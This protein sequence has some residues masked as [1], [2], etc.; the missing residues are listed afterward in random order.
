MVDDN[1]ITIDNEAKGLDK[2]T[3]VAGPTT[4]DPTPPQSKKQAIIE[5]L[6]LCVALFFPLFLATLDTSITH[7]IPR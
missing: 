6:I 2:K 4:T 7:C 3:P 5:K 1:N